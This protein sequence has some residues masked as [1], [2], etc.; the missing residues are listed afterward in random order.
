MIRSYDSREA[1]SALALC[2]RLLTIDICTKAGLCAAVYTR[3]CMRVNKYTGA[4]LGPR[5]WFPKSFGG[6]SVRTEQG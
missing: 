5:G 2:Y 1:A 3:Y 4:K 6:S